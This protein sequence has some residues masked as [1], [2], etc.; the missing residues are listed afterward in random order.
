MTL[1]DKVNALPKWDASDVSQWD[2]AGAIMKDNFVPMGV[3][4]QR[5]LARHLVNGMPSGSEERATM[6]AIVD[7]RLEGFET[8]KDFQVRSTVES[9]RHLVWLMKK[10]GH[11]V[12]MVNAVLASQQDQN[13]GDK[14]EEKAKEEKAKEE[15][16]KEAPKSLVKQGKSQA[17]I[18]AEAL[19]NV[20]LGGEAKIDEDA[21]RALVIDTVKTEAGMQPKRLIIEDKEAKKEIKL[22]LCH[23][24]QEQLIKVLGCKL[25]VWLAGP[26]GTGKTTAAQKA[27]EALDLPFY[28]NG[29]IDSEHKLLGFTDAQGRIVSRPFRKAFEDGGLYLFDE[30]DA[31]MPGALLAFNAAL[32]NDYCD[33]PDGKVQKHPNFRCVAAANTWG[34]GATH[35]Y[36][37]RCKMDAAFLDRFVSIPWDIDEALERSIALSLIEDEDKGGKWVSTVQQARAN[38]AKA[39]IKVVISPRASFAG[40]TLLQAGFPHNEVVNLTIRKGLPDASWKQINPGL[41]ANQA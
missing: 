23:H 28:F 41:K 36:V 37:G 13:G 11:G 34:H 17:E 14:K 32:A 27:A 12:A 31:S 9:V 39:G 18:I 40:A 16:V 19:A 4:R 7:L 15:E 8:I 29:A 20:G 6:G 24:R 35:D 22:G 3:N 2:E 21:I 10:A 1:T 25:N 26:A 33:F 38:V 30:V 5:D